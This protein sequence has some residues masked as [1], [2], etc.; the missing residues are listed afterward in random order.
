MYH[1]LLGAHC[2]NRLAQNLHVF[3]KI[4]GLTKANKIMISRAGDPQKLTAFIKPTLVG[5][6]VH[7]SL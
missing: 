6:Q 2:K 1:E 3:L 5:Y 7:H 4:N